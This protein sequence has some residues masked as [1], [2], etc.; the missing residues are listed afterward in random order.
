MDP[1]VDESADKD[2][3]SIGYV[4]SD[5]DFIDHVPRHDW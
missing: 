5:D 2:D 1:Y 4:S 3:D